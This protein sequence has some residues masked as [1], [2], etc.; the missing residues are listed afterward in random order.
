MSATLRF[1]GGVLAQFDCG[2]SY[3][4]GHHLE[5]VGTRGSVFLAD[6]W[7]GGKGVI[8]LRR[9]GSTEAI[10]TGPANSYALELANFEAAVRGEREP[11]L[12]RADAL[13]QARVIAALYESSERN[14][15]CPID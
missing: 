9:D 13:G 11:L 14:A 6:P 4:G 2:L 7:H 12:G 1:P 10:E 3:Q 5:A 15:P 8:E